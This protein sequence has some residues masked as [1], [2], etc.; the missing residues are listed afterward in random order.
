M[1]IA[2]WFGNKRIRYKKNIA[3]A[4]EEA[5]MYAAK[6]ASSGS[7]ASTPAHSKLLMTFP[8]SRRTATDA[9]DNVLLNINVLYS[10]RLRHAI[11]VRCRPER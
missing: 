6:A 11:A 8:C 3:K 5:N 10:A 9:T 4:Q 1:Q 7:N 2:N